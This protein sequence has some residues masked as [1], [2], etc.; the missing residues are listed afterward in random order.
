MRVQQMPEKELMSNWETIIAFFAPLMA[1]CGWGL[2]KIL[3]LDRNTVTR[4]EF[5]KTVES[6]RGDIKEETAEINRR[7]DSLMQHLMRKD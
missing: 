4:S 6:I 2:R 5:N 3:F 1:F 7:L